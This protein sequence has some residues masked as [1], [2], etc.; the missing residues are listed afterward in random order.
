MSSLVWVLLHA[1]KHWVLGALALTCMLS[2]AAMELMWPQLQKLIIDRSLI[3]GRYDLL[4][5]F[6]VGILALF[7][8]R[9]VL[10]LLRNYL[11]YSFGMATIYDI[12]NRLFDHIQRLSFTY[13]DTAE[14]GQ[15][16]SR[17]TSDIEALNAFLS[18]GILHTVVNLGIVIGILPIC[19]KMNWKLAFVAISC[20]PFIGV[21]V[22]KYNN[23]I[24]PAYTDLQNTLGKLTASIQQNV[25]G[26]KVVKA[27]SRE[28]FEI[29]KFEELGRENYRLQIVIARMGAFYGP[30]MDF[31]AAIGTTFILWYGGMLVLRGALTIGELVA[32]NTYLTLL[33][34]PVSM[35]GWVI[36]VLQN[37]VAA[38]DRI[39]EVLL[40]H[41]E[42]LFRDG[43]REFASC[44]GHV[45]FQYVSFSYKNGVKALDDVSFEVKPGEMV[46]LMGPTGSGKSSIINLISRFYDATEGVVMIDG[47]DVKDYRISHL[48]R[49]IGIVAQDTFLFNATIR[50]NISFARPN[51][52]LEEVEEA[53]RAACIHD[54]VMSLPDKY[55]TLVGERGVNLSGGQRQRLSIAR[56]LLKSPPILILDDSTSALDNETELMIQKSLSSLAEQCTTFMIAQRISALKRADKIIVLNEG[57]IVEMGTHDELVGT[58]GLYTRIYEIQ[59]SGQDAGGVGQSKIQELVDVGSRTR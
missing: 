55:D 27:F 43:S 28:E 56:V 29:D 1:R 57:K 36:S 53:A 47:V 59:L 54:Y 38:A 11:S 33:V 23:K 18:W 50:E 16:I 22:M 20:L 35:I 46:A 19:F 8:V 58:G 21:A 42:T 14:T 51:A 9:G 15:L 10:V 34:G 49:Q 31:I 3:Q 52:S 44:K 6:S 5:F 41:Q 30:L 12:R 2:T 26:I 13:H 24:G 7:A 25:M 40:T 32:F 17:T 37:A 4:P 45:E 39:N 48:R